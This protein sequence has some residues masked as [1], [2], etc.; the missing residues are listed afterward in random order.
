MSDLDLL[1]PKFMW[2]V[3]DNG[4]LDY[5]TVGDLLKEGDNLA[6]ITPHEYTKDEE[7]NIVRT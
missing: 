3:V 2:L 1:G 7:Q 5:N 6:I 4:S